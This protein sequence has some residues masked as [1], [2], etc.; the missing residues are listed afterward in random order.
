MNK[1][2]SKWTYNRNQ[3]QSVASIFCGLYCAC[4]YIFRS[5]NV[6]VA[7]FVRYF[8]NDTGLNNVFVHELMCRILD[9]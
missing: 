2:C 7:R 6:D 5:R 8:T 4:Y 9:I 1:H 3:L